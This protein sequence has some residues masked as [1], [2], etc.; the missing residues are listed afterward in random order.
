MKIHI[1]VSSPCVTAHVSPVEM[2]PTSDHGAIEQFRHTCYELHTFTLKWIWITFGAFHLCYE[3]IMHMLLSSPCVTVHVSPTCG[4]EMCPT[5]DHGAIEQFRHTCYEFVNA[6]VHWQQAA[7]SCVSKQGTLVQIWDPGMQS[8][9]RAKLADLHW[10]VEA[11]WIGATDQYGT[12]HWSWQTSK[13]NE[14]FN[15]TGFTS[16]RYNSTVHYVTNKDVCSAACR[17]LSN[18]R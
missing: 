3:H 6:Q 5:S 14:V 13:L 4:A 18:G 17:D 15:W 11:V 10:N 9:M 7:D 2:Y 12:G 16:L 1:L 8:F